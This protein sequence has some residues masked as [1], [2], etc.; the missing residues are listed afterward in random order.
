MP[1]SFFL[2]QT[3]QMLKTAIHIKGVCLMLRSNIQMGEFIAQLKKLLMSVVVKRNKLA[4]A[5]DS[6][7]EQK[8]AADR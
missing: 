4:V 1:V 5:F 3:A 2:Y 6:D 7:L 8:K